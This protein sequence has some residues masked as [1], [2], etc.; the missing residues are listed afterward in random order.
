MNGW[1][2]DDLRERVVASVRLKGFRGARRLLDL[3]SAIA[4]RSSG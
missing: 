2:L 1:I 3:A 4:R